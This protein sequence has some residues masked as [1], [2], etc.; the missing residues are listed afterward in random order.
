MMTWSFFFYYS[1]APLSTIEPC[2]SAD[3]VAGNQNDLNDLMLQA[4]C[5]PRCETQ[6]MQ[7]T[8]GL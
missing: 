5:T 1:P 4:Q 8:L 3:I 6:I 7:N 2:L